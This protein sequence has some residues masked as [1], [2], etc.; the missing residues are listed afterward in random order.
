MPMLGVH[1]A[2]SVDAKTR[3]PAVSVINTESFVSVIRT[4]TLKDA[5][6]INSLS[7]HLGYESMPFDIA[8]ERLRFLLE[9]VT[10]EVWVFEE[11]SI[12]LG[13]IHVFKANR[14][15]SLSFNEIGG[16]VVDPKARKQGIGRKL[17]EFAAKRAKDK[18][19]ELRVRCNS[20]R[21]ETHQFYTK[22]GF[23]STKAQHV[24]KTCL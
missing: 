7:L 3:A 1:K 6:S 14:V 21:E 2:N 20:Q 24:F 22:A 8:C 15:A 10:D 13:W 17:V 23:T 4:A 5:K 9:S 19:I 18:N 16:L 11:S 12:I